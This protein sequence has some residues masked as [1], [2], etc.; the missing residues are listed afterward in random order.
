MRHE[1]SAVTSA[2]F[3][4]QRDFVF[5]LASHWGVLKRLADVSRGYPVIPNG[6]T[7]L[8][9]ICV[10]VLISVWH[11]H[12]RITLSPLTH[13]GDNTRSIADEKPP[14]ADTG[15]AQHSDCQIDIIDS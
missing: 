15:T 9:T 11:A 2:H 3:L 8:K 5:Q 10:S 12:L 13:Q 6:T 7:S 1:R 14:G 4:E